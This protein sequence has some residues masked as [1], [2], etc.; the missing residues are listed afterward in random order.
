MDSTITGTTDTPRI[1]PEQVLSPFAGLSFPLNVYAHGLLLEEG[2]AEYLHYGLHTRPGCPFTE[3]Q[4]HSSDLML[5]RL[6]PVPCRILEVG[7]G[8]G[9]TLDRL[10]GMGYEIH[11][12]TPDAS[13]IRYIRARLGDAAPVSCVSLESFAG[14]GVS[15]DLMLFQESGQYV[16]PLDIFN[17]ALDLLSPTGELLL[18]DEF[19][20]QRTQPGHEGLHLLR[21]FIAQ[22]ERFGFELLEDMDLSAQAAPTLDYI[23]GVTSRHRAGLMADLGVSG[24]QLD[25]LDRS[26]RA[27]RDKYADGRFGYRLLHFRRT[28]QSP[29]RLRCLDARHCGDF[30]RLF[31]HAFGHPLSERMW[32]WK[33]GEGRGTGI[34]IWHQD[35]E[36]LA[37]Y[38]GTTRDI[39]LFG[40]PETAFQACDL[41]VANAARAFLSHRSPLFMVAAT[42]LERELGF[43][44]RHLLGIGFPNAKAYRA[45]VRLGLYT[46]S[47]GRI[48]RV[49]WPARKHLPSLLAK[50][51]EFDARDA[52]L[53]VKVDECWSAMADSLGTYIVGVRDGAYVLRRYVSHPVKQYRFFVVSRR[54]T[55]RS[56]GVLVLH[57][58]EAGDCEL[59]DVIGARADIPF[60]IGQARRVAIMLGCD[61]LYAWLIDNIVPVFRLPDDAS[62]TDLDV[63]VPGN[64]WTA[65]PPMEFSAGK[66]WLT[67]GDTDFH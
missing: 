9:T 49:D 18:I 46:G 63:V 60:L 3:A 54:F 43:G 35:G 56:M 44:K 1:V 61:R 30:G 48:K 57:R 16:D 19:A 22:A 17:R 31:E 39:L 53:P 62:V 10:A 50:V 52:A 33:Y 12:I 58:D 67:G 34:G 45:P 37:H 5:S 42:F 29:S 14:D 26:N 66:W 27:Y 8:L 2:R 59:L 23:L 15:C 6:P 40:K 47:L 24:A 38:G 13:Q 41:M 28:A 25:D 20:L 64:N 55:G 4:Q 51:R 7:A 65:A 32:H 36:L 21:D 11:G